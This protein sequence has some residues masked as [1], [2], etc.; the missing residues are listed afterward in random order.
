MANTKVCV[1]AGNTGAKEYSM[2]EKYASQGCSIAFMDKN[3]EL[4]RLIKEEIER[5]YHVAVFFFHGDVEQEEDRDIFF[6][7]V[8]EMY[9]GT[10]YIICKNDFAE[11]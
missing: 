9:G 7:A 3:K 2:L 4:G 6:A 5:V 11:G 10:D 8:K 1:L